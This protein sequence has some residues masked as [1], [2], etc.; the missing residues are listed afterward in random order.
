MEMPT[1]E[2][3][4]S[5]LLAYLGF[6]A[7]AVMALLAVYVFVRPPREVF[8]KLLH[9]VAFLSAP[10]VM[11]AASSWTV[12]AAT[13]VAFGAAVW[14]ILAVGERLPWFAS[15]FVQRRPHE[16]RRSL[17]LLFWGDAAI[18]AWCWGLCGKPQVAVASILMW[19]FGD[20]AAALVGKR[21]GRHRISLPFAD[22]KKTWEGSAAMF[23]V[24][25]ML[26]IVCLGPSPAVVLAAL[27]G[28][29]VELITHGGYDTITVPVAN[30]AVLLLLGA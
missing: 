22:H 9:I 17:L 27:A 2:S 20:A 16:V 13:L 1:V 21:F 18:V 30:A 8:R 23:C 12:A 6:L 29:Y 19:G 25:L 15:L 10:L 7:P 28:T 26:G 11:H 5:C 14:P 24:E 4:A 3:V